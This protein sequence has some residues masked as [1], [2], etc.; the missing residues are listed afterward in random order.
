MLNFFKIIQLTRL[1]QRSKL[2]IF[3]HI[4]AIFII[5][6]P[7]IV[8]QLSQIAIAV[9]DTVLLGSLGANALAAGGLGT[10]LAFTIFIILQGILTSVSILIAQ[11]RG[12]N[13]EGKIPEIYFVGVVLSVLLSIPAFILLS[14]IGS[15]LL[16]IGQS[17]ELS[18][19]VDRYVSILRWGAPAVM[20]SGGLMRSFLSAIEKGQI[21]LWVSIGAAILNGFLNYGLIYGKAGLPVLGFLGSATATVIV[22]WLNAIVLFIAIYASKTNRRF[23]EK[24]K[25]NFRLLFEM[26]IIGWPV[27]VTF[28]VEMA[29]FLTASLLMGLLGQTTLAA[30]QIVAN[31]VTTSFMVT[32]GIAQAANI[33]VGFWVGRQDWRTAKLVGF[34]AI[35][36]GVIFMLISGV[37]LFVAPTLIISF[38]LDINDPTNEPTITIIASLLRIAVF[39]QIVDGVQAIAAGALRGLKDTRIPMLLATGGYWIIGFFTGYLLVFYFHLGAAGLWY[40]LT[41][42]FGAVAI[43]LI[44]RFYLAAKNTM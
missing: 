11:A 27:A 19:D 43:A 14:L 35:A 31:I 18:R 4:K 8:A 9:T 20:V 40:G 6:G 13:S 41:V 21:L 26:T 16:A 15:F 12:A 5:A 39:F 23:V 25:I 32:L 44:F 1:K 7:V 30:H 33:Q 37:I 24:S 2:P 38:Y 17:I 10:N 3:S 28:A 29:L 34:I 22:L 42:G 36:M